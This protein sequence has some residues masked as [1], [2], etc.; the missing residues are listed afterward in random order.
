[1]LDQGYHSYYFQTAQGRCPVEE[2]I[3]A[4]D[5]DAQRKFFAKRQL[6]EGFGP[7]LPEPHAKRLGEGIYELR[8]SGRDADF[9]A[10]YFFN[11]HLII[12]TH[13]FKKQTQKT[14]KGE[15][16]LAVQRRQAYAAGKH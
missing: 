12:F 11:G 10:L 7:R 5:S 8:F 16:G 2:F 14:P 13:V 6:L 9:R 15:I 4:L 1:M 3:D